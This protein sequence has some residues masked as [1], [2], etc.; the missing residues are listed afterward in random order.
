MKISYLNSSIFLGLTVLSGSVLAADT[1]PYNYENSA[2]TA[3]FKSALDQVKLTSPDGS[4]KLADASS[5]DPDLSFD[6][7]VTDD[8]RVPSGQN[9]M[10]I[11]HEGASSSRMEFRHLTDFN[12][13]DTNT[14][15]GTIKINSTSD[16]LYEVTVLQVHNSDSDNIGAPLMRI[17]QIVEDGTKFY[18][19]KLRLSACDKDTCD[20]E[21]DTYR[22]LDSSGEPTVATNQHRSFYVQ[23]KD[24]V[25]TMKMDDIRGTLMCQSGGEYSADHCDDDDQEHTNSSGD[26]VIDSDWPEDGF[27]FKTG[28]YIQDVGTT[29]VRYKSLYFDVEG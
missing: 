24:S 6:G 14:M 19:A 4:T 25:V 11:T 26:H 16:G 13:S 27:F 21:Y 18:E 8:F 17:A 7:Y 5:S 15:E 9:Y 28:A 23:V 10:Q 1:A 12:R 20:A 3:I 2:G 29:V 22:W